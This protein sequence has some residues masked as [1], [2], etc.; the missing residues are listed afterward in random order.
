MGWCWFISVTAAARLPAYPVGG[1]AVSIWVNDATRC[2]AGSFTIQRATQV[3]PSRCNAPP[4]RILQ[5]KAPEIAPFACLPA[6]LDSKICQKAFI[7]YFS[8]LPIAANKVCVSGNMPINSDLWMPL[9]AQANPGSISIFDY[10]VKS[11]LVGQIIIIMLMGFS[12]VAWT[13]MIGKYLD[14]SRMRALNVNFERKLMDLRSVLRLSLRGQAAELGPYARLTHLAVDAFHRHGESGGP[15][16]RTASLRMGHVENA[17]QRGVAHQT[18]RYESKM[19]MLGSLVTGAPFLGLLGT[20]WGVMVA[21]G[22]MGV[23]SSNTLQDLAPGVSSALLTTVAGLFVAIPAVFGYNFLLSKA[24]SMVTELENF[25]S[26][27]ADRIEL[28]IEEVFAS[29]ERTRSEQHVPPAAATGYG[30]AFNPAA[31]HPGAAA[32]QGGAAP[33]PHSAQPPHSGSAVRPPLQQ[34]GQPHPGQPGYQH[35][36]ESSSPYA[37]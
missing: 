36:G 29:E 3:D 32:Q 35:P 4:S 31:A 24:K 9:V 7:R 17:L 20:V 1:G 18:I 13:V 25:A 5:P 21:F 19:I 16:R 30:A 6:R 34:P 8:S 10:F 33:A 11:D 14:F 12:L 15:S 28:E 27:L 22:A 23:S 37:G 26:A 2:I